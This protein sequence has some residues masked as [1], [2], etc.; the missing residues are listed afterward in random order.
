MTNN[1]T[2]IKNAVQA[3]KQVTIPDLI[4]QNIDK[5]AMVLPKGM[6]AKRIARIALTNLRTNPKLAEC[7]PTSF[8]SAL[9][10]SAQL[11]LEPGI[12][13]QAYLIPYENSKNQNGTWVKVKEV[14]F[15]IGYKGL[16]ELYYRHPHSSTI[17]IEKVC[18]NDIFEVDLGTSQTIK[19]IPVFKNRGEA[20]CYYAVATLN[21]GNKIIKVMSLEECL[22]HGKKHSK[23]FNRSDSNWT[24]ERDAMCKK[25]VLIQL[26]KV[27]PKSI[28]MQKALAMDCTTKSK[29][30]TDMFEVPDET[31]WNDTENKGETNE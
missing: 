2:Q 27:L 1:V 12:E 7:T 26:M 21:D 24:K 18:E 9:F 14:Q 16:I 17:T 15:Q 29:V 20:I 13:G 3:H 31:N 4:E 6:D 22:E 28:D 30:G 10:Q 11:G 19:H 23:G 5:L 25:T 8:V